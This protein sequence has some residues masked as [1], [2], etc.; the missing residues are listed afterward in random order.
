[1]K[2]QYFARLPQND[3][4]TFVVVGTLVLGVGVMLLTKAVLAG[5]LYKHYGMGF[6]LSGLMIVFA[7]VIMPKRTL[8]GVVALRQAEAFRRFVRRAD[9]AQ[10]ERIAREDPGAFGRFLPYACVLG[11]GEK[12]AYNFRDLLDAGPDYFRVFSG[13]IGPEE[14]GGTKFDSLGYTYGLC[15]AMATINSSIDSR[16]AADVGAPSGSS[17]SRYR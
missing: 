14:K 9:H 5:D 10:F 3:R 17:T 6:A 8:K 4:D 11:V 7:S 2:D 13:D 12:W 16:V 1:V 15:R